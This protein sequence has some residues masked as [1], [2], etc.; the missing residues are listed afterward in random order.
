MCVMTSYARVMESSFNAFAIVA[1]LEVLLFSVILVFLGTGTDTV[2]LQ[3]FIHS[4]CHSAVFRPG[5]NGMY[6]YV[7]VSGTLEMLHVDPH[8]KQ[9]VRRYPVYQGSRAGGW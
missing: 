8:D 5:E 6:W 9:K 1:L 4:Y 7:V 2:I 3:C